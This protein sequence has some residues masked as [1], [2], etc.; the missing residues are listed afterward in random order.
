VSKVNATYTLDKKI[1]EQF[2]AAKG[3]YSKSAL[4]ESWIIDFL[5]K[6]KN[7]SL[8][9]RQ[10]QAKKTPIGQKGVSKNV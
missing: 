3:C 1:L 9:K 4:V 8:I 10:T 5:K 2:N 6:E 7:L